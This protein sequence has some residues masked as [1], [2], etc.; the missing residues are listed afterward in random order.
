MGFLLRLFFFLILPIAIIVLPAA[1]IYFAVEP[2]PL[3]SKNG[4]LSRADYRTAQ[5]FLERYD[6]RRMT[7]GKVTRVTAL[8]SQ[9][10]TALNAGFS[11]VERVSAQ[12]V[13]SRWGLV[14]AVTGVLPVPNNPL[15]R[16]I[17]LRATVAPSNNGLEISRFAIGGIEVPP[18]LTVPAMR[19]A[20]D[21]LVGDG[22]GDEIVNSIQSVSVN[23]KKVTIAYNPP[24]DLVGD[25]KNAARRHAQ[26]SDPRKVKPYYE[27][28]ER[29]ARK[30][31]NPSFTA[32]LKPVF[33]LAR[34]RSV[35]RDP[36]EENR[37]A[38][39]ALAM[40]F[41]DPRIERFIGD[42]R[43]AEQKAATP[44]VGHV[45]IAGRHDFMQHFVI[46]AGLALTG[47]SALANVIGE[48]K[49]V[50]DAG[51]TSGFSFTDLAADRA[52]VMFAQ[53]A[54]ASQASAIRFQ[55]TLSGQPKESDIFP[56]V[57]DLP[58][59][60]SDAEFQRRY[61]DTN[62]SAYGKMVAEIDRR[63]GRIALYR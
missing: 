30:G 2:V 34:D 41:G 57:R 29:T 33:A 37:A 24:A 16:Y 59:G 14:L 63:I 7:A 42:V 45:R 36:V 35:T 25:L 60:L 39:L 48:A 26:V 44:R 40:Y 52:G 27:L 58:E 38:I 32:H 3:V 46:S 50:K 17:N 4:N 12:A 21:Q 9:L 13:V 15:G 56:K 28:I 5:R 54:V 23:G 49:E 10:N 43:T 61:G 18:A 8:E 55:E 22:K 11:S 47:G 51:Q 62:S 1:A 31:R 6:P 53:R 19:L 20:L